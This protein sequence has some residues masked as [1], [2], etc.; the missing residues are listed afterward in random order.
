MYVTGH[1]RTPNRLPTNGQALKLLRVPELQPV[2]VF[3]RPPSIES[4][5]E[6]RG[7]VM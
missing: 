5:R 3:V 1:L 2:V 6:T 7:H 4:L